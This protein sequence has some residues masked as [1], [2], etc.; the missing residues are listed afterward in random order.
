MELFKSSDM[1]RRE[2]TVTYLQMFG[3]PV[4]PP[5]SLPHLAH[6][7]R[8]QS[9]TV[10]Y[11]RFLYRLVGEPWYW[12][13]RHRWSDEQLLEQLL[14][15]YLELWV[16]FYE[17]SPAGYCELIVAPDEVN[18]CYFGLAPDFVG[19]GLGRPWL[20]WTL[21]R[22]WSHRPKRVWLNTCTL[23]HPAALPLYQKLGLEPYRKVV[24]FREL[25]ERD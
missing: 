10:A 6:V 17:G 13:D 8:C 21:R 20:D 5:L 11:Y 3:E 22:C 18:V 19:K 24:E 1:T 7:M 25:P 9:P 14:K 23:D 4:G 12:V 15:P 16:L 2:V